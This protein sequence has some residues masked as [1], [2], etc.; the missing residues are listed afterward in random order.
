MSLANLVNI[1]QLKAHA[2]GAA[3]SLRLL[4][5]AERNLKDSRAASIS[6]ETRFDAGYNAIMQCALVALT[7]SGYRPVTNV[8][9]HHQT[10]IQSLPL[11]LQ[12]ANDDWLVLDALRKKRNINDYTGD[13]IDPASVQECIAQASALL[14]RTRQ[15]L[16]Q[17]HPQL[18]DQAM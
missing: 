2:A 8:P 5:A 11:T 18:L 6:D 17:H 3:E 1:G 7:A 12:I 15:W 14:A 9:G 13:P 16:Q 10:M 4:A